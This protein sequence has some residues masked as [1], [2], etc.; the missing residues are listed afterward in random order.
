[1]KLSSIAMAVLWTMTLACFSVANGQQTRSELQTQNNQNITTNGR[2]AIT[3]AIVN[4]MNS[5]I[6]TSD[7]NLEDTNVWAGTNTFN[8]P[9]TINGLVSPQ[10]TGAGSI[11]GTPF[12]AVGNGE[13]AGLSNA[14]RAAATVDITNYGAVADGNPHQVFCAATGANREADSCATQTAINACRDLYGSGVSGEFQQVSGGCEITWPN[15]RIP[16][17]DSTPFEADNVS[18]TFR[19]RDQSSSPAI[20]N[21]NPMINFGL[22]NGLAPS[23]VTRGSTG[24]NFLPNDVLIITDPA[25]STSDLPQVTVLT[26]DSSGAI[27]T[28]VVSHHGTCSGTLQSPLPYSTSSQG[29]N[30]LFN[31]V[32]SGGGLSTVSPAGV[33]TGC[34]QG[35]VLQAVGGSGANLVS[36]TVTVTQVSGG[37]L[38]AVSILNGGSYGTPPSNPVSFVPTGGSTCTG[39]NLGMS[40]FAAGGTLAFD[41]IKFVAGSP[42]VSLVKGQFNTAMP[43]LMMTK[44]NFD[45]IGTA[46]YWRSIGSFLSLTNPL[47]EHIQVQNN[48]TFLTST[49]AAFTIT[50]QNNLLG[51]Y[52]NHIDDVNS[53]G[54]GGGAFEYDSSYSGAFQGLHFHEVVCGL[55]SYC[56]RLVSTNGVGNFGIVSVTND[57]YS[58]QTATNLDFT[59]VSGLFMENIS[60]GSGNS[61]L[62]PIPTSETVFNMNNVRQATIIGNNCNS[63]NPLT[64][65]L[66]CF[67]FTNGSSSIRMDGNRFVNL[68]SSEGVTEISINAD[69]STSNIKEGPNEL[70]SSGV[71]YPVDA[72]SS[73]A[74]WPGPYAWVTAALTDGGT[75]Q[76]PNDQWQTFFNNGA[77][78]SATIILPVSAPLNAEVK[79]VFFA[80]VAAMTLQAGSGSALAFLPNPSVRNFTAPVDVCVSVNGAW[81]PCSSAGTLASITLPGPYSAAGTPIP[82]CNTAAKGQAVYASDVTTLTPNATYV[83]GGSF[84][85]NLFCNGTNWVY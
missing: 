59:N 1:M 36:T 85:A 60:G 69:S 72:S 64:T 61:G 26:V 70:Y 40:R 12:N 50:A 84:T 45:Y 28:Q 71:T 43:S 46:N 29:L 37:S 65:S 24:Q 16:Y 47:F 55:G 75:Y 54:M 77:I 23:I 58:T 44:V 81:R 19:T 78:N 80:N 17:W 21:A 73:N 15:G 27:L 10:G 74:L 11:M 38:T 4:S 53:F 13:T 79:T 67:N 33:G 31:G 3:G 22:Q 63:A 56:I 82:T 2:G 9:T 5:A 41:N 14:Q 49:A 66:T 18:L 6:I 7:G 68:A 57:G 51:H 39:V 42:G 48:R 8:G 25:C 76:I 83:S 34:Q 52:E 35:D 62:T 32:I 20:V 30:A